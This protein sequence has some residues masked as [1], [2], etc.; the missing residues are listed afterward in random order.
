MLIYLKERQ[1]LIPLIKMWRC[2]GLPAVVKSLSDC[3][4]VVAH[5]FSLSLEIGN[6]EII[7][8]K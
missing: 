6:H 1:A 2:V 4:E 3:S 7:E 8:L 5:F